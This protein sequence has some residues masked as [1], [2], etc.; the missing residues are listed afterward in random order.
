MFTISYNDL[1]SIHRHQTTVDIKYGHI[2]PPTHHLQ[3][4]V[5]RVNFVWKKKS[6]K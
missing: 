2:T 6:F 3:C 4:Q 5:N 1:A